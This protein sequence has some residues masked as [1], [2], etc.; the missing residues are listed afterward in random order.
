MQTNYDTDPAIARAGMLADS[1]LLKHTASRLASGPIK[2]GMGVFRVP[3]FGS[4]GTHGADPGQVYQNPTPA[5]ALDV[6]AII[7]TIATTTGIQTLVAADADGVV[8]VAEMY[9]ARRVTLTVDAH[10][11]WDPT[12]GV[13]TYV[14][15]EGIMVTEDLAIASSAALT[16]VGYVRQFVSFVI[17]AQTGT[18]GTATMGVAVL[19]SG[20]TLADFEGVAL[21][22]ASVEPYLTTPAASAAEFGDGDAIP[23]LVRGAVWVATEDACSA[24]QPVYLRIGG[25]A[26]GTQLGAFRSDT[27]SATAVLVT[28]ARYA[29]DSAIAGLN[30]VEFY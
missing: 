16:T 11:D 27:D 6:D 23:V 1:R 13:L 9:P 18:G 24:G 12:T 21:Y 22:D 28:N 7:A 4:P 19:D 8:G 3:G 26:G 30:K 29:R 25:G 15:Q 10:A 17:P 2:A 14:N 5:V 20:I